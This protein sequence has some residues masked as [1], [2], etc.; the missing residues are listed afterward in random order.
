[1]R[2]KLLA[3]ILTVG[4]LW[5]AGIDPAAAQGDGQDDLPP[6]TSDDFAPLGEIAGGLFDLI[7]GQATFDP[8]ILLTWWAQ[9]R[10]LTPPECAEGR[11]TYLQLR[12]AADEL[13]VGALLL[14]RDPTQTTDAVLAINGGLDALLNLRFV[15]NVTATSGGG[16]PAAAPGDLTADG[17]LAALQ[18][19]DLPFDGVTRDAGPAGRGAPRTEAERVTFDLP[20]VF[21]GGV[22]Q[23]LVFADQAGLN[24]WVSYLYGLDDQTRGYVYIQQNVILQLDGGLSEATA[25]DFNHALA[26]LN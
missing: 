23:L 11:L 20:D 24:A 5:G 10:D 4:L 3:V 13:L 2:R 8:D 7:S 17:V 25:A 18:A 26:A 21:D 14:E 16:V 1:M 6:C 9:V 15:L 19:A 12:T 22:G